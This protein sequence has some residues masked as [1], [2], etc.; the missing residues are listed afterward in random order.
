[1]R[2]GEGGI[3]RKILPVS[4]DRRATVLEKGWVEDAGA[5]GVLRRW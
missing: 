5:G 3:V 2:G 1:M 4:W